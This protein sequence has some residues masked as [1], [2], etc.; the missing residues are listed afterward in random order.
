[1]SL[2]VRFCGFGVKRVREWLAVI[3]SEGLSSSLR[4]ILAVGWKV[5]FGG[6]NRSRFRARIR[7]CSKCPIYDPVLKKCRPYPGSEL[8]CGCYVPFKALIR[9]PYRGPAGEGCWGDAILTVEEA[10]EVGWRYGVK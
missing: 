2:R 5:L 8:G 10:P 9:I 7:R 6:V 1:M 3:R 4:G